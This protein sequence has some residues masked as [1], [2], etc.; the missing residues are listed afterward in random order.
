MH[1]NT[2]SAGRRVHLH[3]YLIDVLL[4]HGL[5]QPFN[6]LLAI[7]P[8]TKA[9][10]TV[11]LCHKQGHNSTRVGDRLQRAHMMVRASY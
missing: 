9:I 11:F 10:S 6:Q 4:V 2:T 8:I 3:C 7:L 1:M 5:H